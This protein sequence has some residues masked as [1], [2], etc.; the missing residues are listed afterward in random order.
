M[1]V[2]P[3][4]NVPSGESLVRQILY[5]VK[6]FA[7][8]FGTRSTILWEPDVF[9]YTGALPQILSKSGVDCFMTQKLSWNQVTK[10]PH[11]TFWWQGIDGSRVLAHLPPEDTYNGP[12]APRSLVKLENDYLDKG[13]SDRALMLF[14]I[15]DGGGG[16]GE[17]HLERLLR[18]KN[19]SG[20]CPVIQEPAEK[21]FSRLRDGSDRYSTWVGE[22]YLEKHQGTFTSQARNKKF[23]RK[24]EFALREL[25]L[26]AV[27][28]MRSSASYKYPKAQTDDIWRE[29]L[30]LQFHDILPGSSI[31]RVYDE[32]VPRYAA[33]LE[34]VEKLT[35]D[36]ESVGGGKSTAISNSLSWS[37]SQWLKVDGKWRHVTVP[38]MNVTV[39][40][41]AAVQTRIEISGSKHHLE[42]DQLRIEF[43]ADGT[44]TSCYDKAAKRE[45]LS[46]PA[47]V[48]ALYEDQGDAWDFPMD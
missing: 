5:G 38:P 43:A 19:L 15:G 40:S 8:E 21:F 29:V 33:L 24:I 6:F 35:R 37:R 18:E 13:V 11:H 30:L 41:N 32:S 26:A 16:P 34:Q 20:L 14:G 10:H 9:G 1:W 42:N 2:E 47:N 36:A 46:A 44:I 22:L 7:Q 25:E 39:L 3:D 48:L 28:A 12:A 4:T 23:N 45:T 31:Q 27:I 17:E